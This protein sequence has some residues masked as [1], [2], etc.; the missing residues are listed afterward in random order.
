MLSDFE[1]ARFLL[2]DDEEPNLR[3][4]ERILERAGYT[5]YKSTTDPRDAL[6][7]FLEFEPDL[8]LLD[9]H[10][11]HIDGFAVMDELRHRMPGGAHVPVLVLTGDVSPD[12]RRRALACGARDFLNK[13]FDVAEV[14]LRIK[15]LLEMRFLQLQLQRQNELLEQRVRERTR[16]L[17]GARI[18]I[19]ERLA[20]AAEFRD[21]TTGQHTQRVGR[22]S[23]L[24]ARSLGL[25]AP[26]V[27][28]IRRAAPLHDVGKIG[29]P[30]S[31]LLRPGQLGERE[32]EV[33]RTH[34]YI[35]ARI[36]SGSRFPLLDVAA[37]I[38]LTHHERW[39]GTGY[40]KGLRGESIP[41]V[42]RIVAVADVFDALTHDRPYK[43]AWPVEDAL[44][45]IERQAGR[46]F[47]PQVVEAF[48]ETLRR[49]GFLGSGVREATGVQ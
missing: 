48:L 44:A 31:I 6:P 45:E 12:V 32:F 1:N 40:P 21:D 49:M 37:T 36:L 9:L 10:M 17:E 46:Q 13:P 14:L 24:V 28:L 35:G 19:L 20:R 27:D 47:D 30:D 29:I 7:I 41:M 39:D 42:G 23:A 22:I 2:V 11:P 4:L 43:A 16:E 3:L 25:P 33:M 15:N 8:V 5:Q 26:Q 34:T 38:A 18:E